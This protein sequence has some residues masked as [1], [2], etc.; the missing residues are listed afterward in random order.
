MDLKEAYEY[1]IRYQKWRTGEDERTMK[2]AG[3]HP[4]EVTEALNTVL[5]NTESSLVKEGKL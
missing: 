1:L 5:R 2:S 4:G 3:I